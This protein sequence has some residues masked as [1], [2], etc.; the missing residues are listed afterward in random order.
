MNKTINDKRIIGAND[1]QGM[2]TYV[3]SSH[4]VHMDMRGHRGGVS[5]FGIGVFTA[6]PS[7]QNM[8]LRISNESGLIGNS[9][10]LMYNILY[11]YFLESQG[12]PMKYNRTWKNNEA[13]EKMAKNGKVS[14]SINCRDIG[15]KL[16]WVYYREKQGKTSIKHCPIDKTFADL[17]T[18]H[19]Q[20]SRFKM[21]R[22]VVM[23]WDDVATLWDDSDDKYKVSSTS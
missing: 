18:K 11:E 8:N 21:F 9:E 23:G 3:D 6:K 15:I 1:I 16:L 12:Y 13:A 19:L 4:A 22:K 5:N 17:F 14:C 20:G 7:K 2:Q 10:Y